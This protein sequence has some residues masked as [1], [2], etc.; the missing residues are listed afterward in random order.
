MSNVNEDIDMANLALDSTALETSSKLL[1]PI[2][3]GTSVVDM[4]AG[5]QQIQDGKTGAGVVKM[6]KGSTGVATGIAAIAGSKLAGPV[7]LAAS[8]G[9]DSGDYLQQ[10][11]HTGDQIG[12]W[13][14]DVHHGTQGFS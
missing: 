10:R 9:L 14:Q 12:D 4:Y 5:Y 3:I 7:G 13:A 6:T 8:A 11:Y 2:T 1:S